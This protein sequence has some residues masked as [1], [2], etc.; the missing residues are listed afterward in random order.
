MKRIRLGII[1]LLLAIL[2]GGCTATSLP[3]LQTAQ[4]VTL[5]AQVL[6]P[7]LALLEQ[8][9]VTRE[10]IGEAQAACSNLLQALTHA[11]EA[12][13]LRAE[14][15]VPDTGAPDA[16]PVTAPVPGDVDDSALWHYLDPWPDAPGFVPSRSVV[17][18]WP[19]HYDPMVARL[20]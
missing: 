17:R 9:G 1:G 6:C 16:G 13:R 3:A 5:T 8:A 12:A 20:L 19:P 10:E 14:R 11:L 2:T 7:S 4:A 15:R 18:T